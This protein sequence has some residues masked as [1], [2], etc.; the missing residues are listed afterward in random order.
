[1]FNSQFLPI[2]EC[3]KRFLLLRWCG[4]EGN[5]DSNVR[6]T[7]G[8]YEYEICRNEDFTETR[9]SSV[10]F[11]PSSHYKTNQTSVGDEAKSGSDTDVDFTLRNV[12]DV[13]AETT[14]AGN[15]DDDPIT[16]RWKDTS[17]TVLTSMN[18][19]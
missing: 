4:Y 6:L 15:N 8:K 16:T 7:G 19:R 2:S 5:D 11:S 10:V 12:E 14:S 9:G 17:L 1:M 3:C 18:K 13:I